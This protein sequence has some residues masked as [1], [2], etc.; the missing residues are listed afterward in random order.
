M[1]K[2]IS[3][4]LTTLVACWDEASKFTPEEVNVDEEKFEKVENVD[5]ERV[6]LA[7]NTNNWIEH[8][9]RIVDQHNAFDREALERIAVYAD[10]ERSGR[11]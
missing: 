9:Q 5:S 3:A 10:R 11:S 8:A 1:R 2:E 4:S 7:L 6:I